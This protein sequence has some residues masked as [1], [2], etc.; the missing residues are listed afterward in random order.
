MKHDVCVFVRCVTLMTAMGGGGAARNSKKVNFKAGIELHFNKLMTMKEN[1][2]H[3]LAIHV[4]LSVRVVVHSTY[5]R[6]LIVIYL[7]AIHYNFDFIDFFC[8][9]DQILNPLEK[10]II[11]KKKSRMSLQF[12]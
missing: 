8:K 10:L 11:G 4:R 9:I 12:D 3:E 6:F 7:A 5:P 2:L 1:I